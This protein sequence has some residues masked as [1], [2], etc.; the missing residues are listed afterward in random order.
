VGRQVVA[1]V[2]GWVLGGLVVCFLVFSFS[3]LLTHS[4]TF[5]Y[6]LLDARYSGLSELEAV[7]ELHTAAG[8]ASP[9]VFKLV[10]VGCYPCR[11]FIRKHLTCKVQIGKVMLSQTV[12]SCV[13][14]SLELAKCK[15]RWLS[16]EP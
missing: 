14:I 15:L 7:G 2:G 13:L 4:L 16:D 6:A 8:V 11:P 10:Y 3:C 9:F 1:C 12:A 5:T